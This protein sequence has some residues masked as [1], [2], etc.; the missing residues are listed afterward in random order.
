MR[1][2]IEDLE[3]ANL[4]MHLLA[5]LLKTRIA[6]P[7]VAKKAARVKGLLHLTAGGMEALIE[8][9]TETDAIVVRKPKSAL[10][11]NGKQQV[12]TAS[13]EGSLPAF[14]SVATRGASSSLLPLIK[15]QLTVSGNLRFL[16][17]AVPLLLP[18]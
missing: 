4:L 16:S 12:A 11:A 18:S 17:R 5:S 6:N 15:R 2:E 7:A 8:F 10:S 14:L 1:V 3:G 9:R 13:V